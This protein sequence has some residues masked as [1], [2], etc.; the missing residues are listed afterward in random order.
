MGILVLQF[1]TFAVPFALVFA[2]FFGFA[3]AAGGLAR[4]SPGAG[5]PGVIALIAGT[6][7]M[8][9]VVVIVIL[10]AQLLFGW[11]PAVS[12]VRDLGALDSYR[13]SL[14]LFSRHKLDSLLLFLLAVF[15]VQF[16]SLFVFMAAFVCALPGLVMV[17]LGAA[18]HL[19]ALV[20][21][22]IVVAVMLALAAM[23][24]VGGFLGAAQQVTYALAC[25]DLAIAD[26]IISAP[27]TWRGAPAGHDLP[28]AAVPA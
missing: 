15:G 20:V 2:L 5:A 26:G 23:L 25:R 24:L 21:V 16:L 4:Q 7:G 10:G 12:V 27:P 6:L 17:V 14:R 19:V 18:I 22:G 11:A 8:E 3:T 9:L 1:A 13:E 28:P